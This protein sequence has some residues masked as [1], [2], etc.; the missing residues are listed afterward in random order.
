MGVLVHKVIARTQSHQFIGKV[1]IAW[2]KYAIQWRSFQFKKKIISIH[3]L[4]I[5]SM[6]ILHR[7]PNFSFGLFSLDWQFVFTVSYT[8]W[9]SKISLSVNNKFLVCRIG[10][11][12][13][14]H[15]DSVSRIFGYNFQH[16]ITSSEPRKGRQ[17]RTVYQ[18]NVR[19]KRLH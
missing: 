4:K 5:L 10:C 11:I 12:V 15:S 7:S 9:L 19:Q 14:I 3:Q 6:Q 13:S 2:Q 1:K 16:S 8:F 17:S 18:E